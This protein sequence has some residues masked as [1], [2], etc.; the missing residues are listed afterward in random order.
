VVSQC[1][2]AFERSRLFDEEQFLR[3]RS[4][5]LQNMTA[6]LSNALTR[7]DV[8]EVV[9]EQIG[10]A[11]D[12]SGTAV[13]IVVEDRQLVRTLAWRGYS[14]HAMERR[15]EVPLDTPTPGNRAIKRRVSTFYES[16]DE[17]R[18]E[19]SAVSEELARIEHAAFLFVPLVVGREANGL[20]SMSWAEPHAL[21]A[22]ERRF[23]ESLASQAA[24]ALDRA[25]RFESERTIAET[26]QRSFLPSS[27]PRVRGVQLAARYLPGTAELEVGGDWFDAI[28]L[29][30]G[31]IGLVVGDVVGKGVQAAATM[32]QLRNAL[33]AFALDR[34][35]P[36][37][38]L[39]RLNRLAE[40]TFETTFATIVYAIL[41]RE[42][43]ICRF[44][45]AGHPPPLIAYPDGRAELLEGGRGLPLGAG[46]D[47]RYGHDTVEMPVGSVLL[48]YTDGLVERRDRPIDDGLELLLA[49]A[50]GGPRDPEQLVEHIL[51]RLVGSGERGDDIAVLALGL[52]AVAPERLH[53]R[54]P[55]QVDS[56]DLVRDSVRVWLEGTSLDDSDVRDVVLATW[57]ACA[58]AV[59]HA[60]DPAD[61]YVTVNASLTESAV[62]ITVDDTGGWAPPAERSDRGL[63]LRLMH[64]TMTSVDIATDG[65]GTK[66]TLEKSLG[67]AGE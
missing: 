15:L 33:R 56:L 11:L 26:F 12:A 52:Q 45:A 23:V 62:Q 16:F 37:S 34:M 21:S 9:V 4:E 24:Q 1:A 25:S 10:E 41:D 63:G 58:N 20:L 44:T 59:E 47:S 27:L 39:A 5:Q 14:D 55:R 28:A 32:A 65:G 49:T 6:A 35:K 50:L 53:V 36:S 66:V 48:L 30:E 43:R 54:V 2:Q 38:T 8:A 40:E 57:E 67:E 17:L 61:D 7:A 22:E 13:A 3:R 60:R 31:R 19:F 18:G 64:A 42:S 46:A 51:E 29:E